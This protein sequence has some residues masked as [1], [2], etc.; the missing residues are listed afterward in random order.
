MI[1]K[2]MDMGDS[3][4]ESMQGVMA[5]VT[6]FGMVEA[7]AIQDVTFNSSFFRFDSRESQQQTVSAKTNI[8]SFSEEE[9]VN[10]TLNVEGS[11]LM[12]K[13]FSSDG[14]EDFPFSHWLWGNQ[15]HS[16]YEHLLG[17][18]VLNFEVNSF[19][20]DNKVVKE[21]TIDEDNVKEI[22]HPVQV[23]FILEANLT[24]INDGES[25][26]FIFGFTDTSASMWNPAD[27]DEVINNSDSTYTVTSPESD[28]ETGLLG[29]LSTFAETKNPSDNKFFIGQ[30]NLVGEDWILESQAGIVNWL[31]I[32]KLKLFRR[33][34][35]NDFID[36]DLY[37]NMEGRVDTVSG[38][39]TGEPEHTSGQRSDYYQGRE[40]VETYSQRQGVSLD[41]RITD[42]KISP[43]KE[44]R[45]LRTKGSK[46]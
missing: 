35:L 6:A 26:N 7:W 37:A 38:D 41:K 32:I 18:S 42:T 30:R 28:S 31:K 16:D 21:L 22:K 36:F 5:P 19:F 25:P 8:V 23:N 27:F 34:L 2:A 15:E 17:E 45:I 29:G 10:P 13:D 11:Y 46:Y 43:K 39:Y 3:P 12:V 1:P 14:S 44:R 4:E 24:E 40:G 20:S 33:V 9:G